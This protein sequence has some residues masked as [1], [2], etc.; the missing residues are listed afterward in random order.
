MEYFNKP[1]GMEPVKE[2]KMFLLHLDTPRML[3]LSCVIIAIV[4]V[5][6]LIGM[7]LKKKSATDPLAQNDPFL[8]NAISETVPDTIDEQSII[9]SNADDDK[10]NAIL[11]SSD[12]GT[13]NTENSTSDKPDILT[14]DNIKE[15]IPATANNKSTQTVSENKNTK[16]TIDN[17]KVS[18]NTKTESKVKK[19]SS[20]G[21]VVEVSN[22]ITT[23]KHT[24]KPN[25]DFYAIQIGSYDKNAKAID[26]IAVLKRMGYTGYIDKSNVNGKIYFR[27][28]IGPIDSKSKALTLLNKLQ[29]N[30][31]YASSYM[32][33]EKK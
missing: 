25:S 20:S 23:P 10:N 22:I 30:T 13:L 6:F 3:I 7:N 18:N 19:N 1:E 27:V 4:A 28:K 31:K 17:V 12:T 32:V 5:S 26:E 24:I 33:H 8:S 21:R 14:Y 16:R 9:S 11:S 2:K 29:N 15:V